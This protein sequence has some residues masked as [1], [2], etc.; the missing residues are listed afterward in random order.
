MLELLKR[1]EGLGAIFADLRTYDVDETSVYVTETTK[2]VTSLGREA[3]SSLRVLVNGNWGYYSFSKSTGDE[4][5]SAVKSAYGDERINIVF[6]PP[7]RDRVKVLPKKEVNKSVEEIM[8]DAEK[9]KEAVMRSHPSVKSVNVRIFISK[10]N[11]GYF[12]TEEREIEMSYSI[13]GVSIRATAREGEVTASASASLSTHLGYPLEVFDVNQTVEVVRKRLENQLKGRPP[14]GGDADVVLAP[15][16]VGVFSHEALGHL[17][18]ADLA[19]NGILGELR[20]K[21]IA[22]DFVTVV[23]SGVLDHPMAHGFTPYDDEGVESREVK[24]VDRGLVSEMLVDRFY[25]AYLGERPTGNGR[26]EDFRSPL[27][28]RMR[29]TYMKPGSWSKEE[30]L[31][32]VKSGYL[33]VSPL[34]GQTSPDGTF[35]FGIQEG[36]VIENGEIQGTLRNT[37]ISGYTIETLG[38]IT[39]VSKDFDVWP[40]HCGKGGQ[41]VPVSTGGPYIRVKVKVG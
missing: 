21:K 12:S 39:A 10:I 13:S 32:D 31:K 26:A 35:Q 22:E 41:S 33:L 36:Y 23:D 20:G 29:N 27:L 4:A 5:E 24:I 1:A 37:A 28:I 25:S 2:Q 17:A 30:L 15:D 6:L 9:I 8:R 19:V 7:K 34:G 18:E 40:G 16:V 11:K 3:G 38:K 14:R